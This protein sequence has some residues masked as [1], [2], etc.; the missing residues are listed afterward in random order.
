MGGVFYLVKARLPPLALAVESQRSW[1]VI[2]PPEGMRDLP[3]DKRL[4]RK[5][6]RGASSPSPL[7]PAFHL[8]PRD[9]A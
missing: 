3:V 6:R 1:A 2:S 7:Q 4:E 8:S 5:C 9:F